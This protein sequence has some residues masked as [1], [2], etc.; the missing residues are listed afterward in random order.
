M[1]EQTELQALNTRIVEQLTGAP[2]PGALPVA[3]VRRAREEGRSVFG[4]IHRFDRA[5]DETL[6]TPLGEIPVRVIRPTGATRGVYLH[7]HG[8]GWALGG[9][10]HQDPRLVRLADATGQVVI[11]VG[12]RLAP[13][14]PYPAGPDDCEAAALAVIGR[15]SADHGSDRITIGGESAGAHLAVVTALRLRDRHGFT[16]LRAA[17][18]LYGVFD[19]AVTPGAR[20]F[21][22]GPQVLTTDSIRWFVDQFAPG[23]DVS[24]PDLSPVHADLVGMPP[25]IFTVGTNDPL[26]DDTLAME[27]RWRSSGIDTALQVFQDAPHAFDAFD[28]AASRRALDAIEEFLSQ[29]LGA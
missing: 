13:E 27:R 5:S 25:A 19:L 18:L 17:N 29:R 15:A 6:A 1:T 22:S 20:S 2:G 11:S 10:D 16:G 7:F 21:G 4:P 23:L 12:Y 14:H 26:L 28:V 9:P 8:G 3:A 24:S